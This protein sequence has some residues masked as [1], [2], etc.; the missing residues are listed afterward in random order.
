[1]RCIYWTTFVILTIFARYVDWWLIICKLCKFGEYICYDSRHIEIFLGVTFL[2]R[3][4]RS[5]LCYSVA[6]VVIWEI[7]WYQNK[8]LWPLFRGRI[9]ITSTIASYS[10]LNISETVIDR[11]L[12]PKDHQWH[13]G[14]KMV[15]WPCIR[16]NSWPQNAYSAIS[17]KQLE[18]LFSNNRF[19]LDSLLCGS[20]VGYPSD[21]LASCLYYTH[22]YITEKDPTSLP[23]SISPK[24]LSFLCRRRSFFISE[25]RRYQ[26]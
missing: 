20:T 4:V 17:R 13:M 2:A 26:L 25:M 8:W 1:M 22:Y 6:S 9:K 10:A 3:P 21:S 18:M 12:V 11:G 5:R 23:V 7:D 15:T 24:S 16:S 14:H 19:L